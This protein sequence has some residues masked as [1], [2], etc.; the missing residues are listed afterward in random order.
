MTERIICAGFGGQ[1]IM[2]MSKII[3]QA[4]ADKRK[5]V[6]W[7]PSY[8]AEVRG[9]TAHCIVVISNQ[10]IGSAFIEQA[11]SLIIM[12]EPSLVRF[13][14]CL[15]KGGLLILND[16][17]VNLAVEGKDIRLYR[18]PLTETAIKIG[19]IRVANMIALGAYAAAKNSLNPADLLQAIGHLLS[20]KKNMIAINTQAFEA[21][22]RLVR[23]YG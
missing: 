16:S 14:G 4:A 11:D 22:I 1:G 19:N 5:Q 6:T 8:G 18:L 3:A 20:A 10:P 23:E 7:I 2:L 13:K 12:N 15:N 9:G 17:L 21:G